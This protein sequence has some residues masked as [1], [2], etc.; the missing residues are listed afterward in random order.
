M[1]RPPKAASVIKLEKKSHRTKRELAA[2][3]AAEKNTLTGKAMIE[4]ANVKSDPK[5]HREFLRLKPLLKQIGKYDEIYGAAVRRYCFNT[6]RLG[7]VEAELIEL[8]NELAELRDDKGEFVDAD[9]IKEYYRLL[10]R[11]EDTITK[12]EQVAKSYRAELTDFEKE[13][14]MTIRSALRSIAK[15]PETKTNALKDALNG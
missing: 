6:S 2:R 5:A 4:T 15:Q 13:N 14:C 1:G 10:T 9:D 3:E 11:L 8:K 12:K 7:E